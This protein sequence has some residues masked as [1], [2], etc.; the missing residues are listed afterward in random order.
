MR[1]SFCLCLASLLLSGILTATAQCTIDSSQ[2]AAGVYPNVLPDATAGQLYSTDV[3]F[4]MLLDTLGLPITNYHITTVTGLPIGMNWQCNNYANGCNY[5]PTVNLYGCANI[6]GTPLIPGSYIAHVT[7]IA[8][9]SVVGDQTVDYPLPI[10]V[11]PAQSTNNGFSMS[12]SSGCDPLTVTFTNNNPGQ[13][14]YQWD[15]GDGIQSNL[16]N[17]P[18]HT[19]TLP[20]DYI[21]TQTVMPN[22]IPDYYLTSVT[23]NS[24]PNNYGAPFDDPD[25]YLLVRNAG[26]TTVYDSR[27]A[28]NGLFPP[29]TWG[30]PNILLANENY[31]IH[32]WDEDGGLFGADDD[33]GVITFAG[34]GTSGNATATVGGASGTLNLDYVI[35]QTPVN[36]IITTDTIH[37]YP[38]QAVPV[39]TISGSTSF[40]EGDSLVL[41]S[42]EPAGN[43]WFVDGTTLTGDTNSTYVITQSGLYS[44]T[45][46][47]SYGC[48]A[49]AFMNDTVHVYPNPPHPTIFI[50]GDT[51]KCL[52]AGYSYQW[53]QNDTAISGETN[54]YFVPTV[55]GNYSVV[56]STLQGCSDTSQVLFF[57]VSGIGDLSGNTPEVLVYPNPANKTLHIECEQPGEVVLK[58]VDPAGKIVFEKTALGRT[59]HLHETLDVS[60]IAKGIYFLELDMEGKK[61]TR[62]IAVN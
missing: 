28:Q 14:S 24:I 19:Y 38:A 10:T 4:V 49:S 45:V 41:T 29:Q 36:P 42:S 9:V 15:F 32:V 5:D 25:M 57:T 8:S 16:E 58:L 40:C 33:L 47:N 22:V 20:G 48:S 44:L 54:F 59:G 35:L 7:V 17:P 2:T 52:L 30:I 11:L 50:A 6:G 13:L 18:A 21:V 31:T 46:T 53:L 39:L 37:V 51:L 27:P 23:V 34:H 3:T 61:L 60:G 62:K 26:G 55:T 56:I 43:Q 12:N 1:K